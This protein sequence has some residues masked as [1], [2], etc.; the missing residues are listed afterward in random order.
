MK[1][2]SDR[3]TQSQRLS[4]RGAKCRIRD[5]ALGRG[6]RN[7]SA[8]AMESRAPLGWWD[9]PDPYWNTRVFSSQR[10][11]A[12]TEA[13][14]SAIKG[15]LILAGQPDA[16]YRERFHRS[17]AVLE[18][19]AETLTSAELYR[20]IVAVLRGTGRAL[21][22]QVA[23][24]TGC[25]TLAQFR[26]E[27]KPLIEAEIIETAWHHAP[28]VAWPRVKAMQL[29]WG[30]AYRAWA[31]KIIEQGEGPDVFGCMRPAL[32]SRSDMHRSRATRHQCLSTEAA[33]RAMETNDIWAGWIPESG[34]RP[35][36]FLPQTHSHKHDDTNLIADGCL[37]RNDGA[38]I[39][40]EIE[41]GTGAKTDNF[42][43]K[44]ESW[45]NLFNDGPFGAILLFIV[46]AQPASM[47]T[48]TQ[49]VRKAVQENATGEAKRSILVASWHDYSPDYGL[50][51]A[52]AGTLRA[53]RLNKTGRTWEETTAAETETHNTEPGITQRIRTLSFNPKWANLGHTPHTHQPETAT[54]DTAK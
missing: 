44:V 39:F 38:R 6:W 43:Q 4:A 45:S 50:V 20:S 51:T 15:D 11:W 29:R 48:A 53:A 25:S 32:S 22:E 16:A 42:A 36:W 31:I 28:G 8:A 1:T 24:L 3:S 12:G 18:R 33:L 5:H 30:P 52:D 10:G 17:R 19:Q 41:A 34:C 9:R 40:L 23:A 26:R 2:H 37:I 13:P 46:A 47:G 14:A 35:E 49:A 27:A 54:A 7:V 21:E